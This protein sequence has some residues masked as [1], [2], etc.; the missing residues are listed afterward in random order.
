MKN[1]KRLNAIAMSVVLLIAMT[2]CSNSATEKDDVST[3]DSVQTESAK[4]EKLSDSEEATESLSWKPE[5]SIEL[6]VGSAPGGG[7][8]LHART[9]SEIAYQKGFI[10]E[11]MVISYKTGGTGNVAFQYLTS[12]K[13]DPYVLMIGNTSYGIAAEL[14]EA[15]IKVEDIG[16]LGVMA[17]DEY[18]ICVNKDS[19]YKSFEDLVE[20][21]KANPGTMKVS[22]GL[23]G[24]I[25]HAGWEIFAKT[26]GVEGTYVGFDGQSDA[27]TALLGKHIDVAIL[28]PAACMGQ[29]ES[30]DFIPIFSFRED[31]L[32][33]GPFKGVPTVKSKGYDVV[34]QLGRL[35][36]GTPDMPKEAVAFYE[37]LIKK[38]MDT[39]EWK[40]YIENNYLTEKYMNAA[41][42]RE[43]LL[44][45]T[46]K[47]TT[48]LKEQ[49]L[50]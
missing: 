20:A 49:E 31:I 8:D 24:S 4:E 45:E 23:I 22:G 47:I 28:T 37:D 44:T 27:A 3:A 26:V 17:V 43:W 11:P 12:K 50:F 9:F 30:G 18:M 40:D 10:S 36:L 19:P 2:G 41:D 34:V 48:V 7:A 33:D 14:N 15:P 46:D 21:M 16:V 25:D 38:V 32:E 13:D 42:A 5:K 35:I 6:V 1:L 29:V 39:Q